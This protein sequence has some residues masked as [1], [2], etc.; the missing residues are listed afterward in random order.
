M[1]ATHSLT[2][3]RKGNVGRYFC[4]REVPAVIYSDNGSLQL[5]MVEQHYATFETLSSM[6]SEVIILSHYHYASEG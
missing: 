2:A 4:D 3:R 1:G 6:G 5:A